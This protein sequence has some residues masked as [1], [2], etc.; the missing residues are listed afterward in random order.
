MKITQISY[1]II[2]PRLSD[3]AAAIKLLS[4][5]TGTVKRIGLAPG[6]GGYVVDLPRPL[7]VDEQRC[8]GALAYG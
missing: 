6:N 1:V 2:H 4:E 8:V 7:T 3:T 5:V